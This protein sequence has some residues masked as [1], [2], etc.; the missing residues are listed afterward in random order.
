[1]VSS[2]TFTILAVSALGG[3]DAIPTTLQARSDSPSCR[4]SI[5]Q[6]AFCNADG[7]ITDN[8]AMP[9]L[10]AS[11]LGFEECVNSCAVADGCKT[12]YWMAGTCAIYSGQLTRANFGP[13]GNG[14][15]W[16]DISCFDCGTVDPILDLD[17]ENQNVDDWSISDDTENN[18]Y[19]D[20]QTPETAVKGSTHAFRVLEGGETGSARVQ[21]NPAIPVEVGTYK[22]GFT[23]K[24]NYQP[25]PTSSTKWEFVTVT[26]SSVGRDLY[27]GPPGGGSLGRGWYQF[28]MDFEVADGQEGP[29]YLSFAMSASGF[30]LDYYFDDIYIVK[31]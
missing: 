29:A 1:M 12:I 26:V 16:N 17:F 24:N 2:K 31:T 11:A 14:G 19:F 30:L 5:Y 4:P 8:Q 18:Y 20:I 21:Y 13:G 3:V 15:F 22:L 7:Y 28:E 10:H 9:F 27:R 6:D 25:D 23:A